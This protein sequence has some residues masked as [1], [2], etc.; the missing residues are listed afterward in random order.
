VTSPVEVTIEVAALAAELGAAVVEAA[1]VA[2]A[3]PAEV[4]TAPPAPAADAD[5]APAASMHDVDV[6]VCMTTGEA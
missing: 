3:L 6:P 1:E 2:L 4:A 5:E